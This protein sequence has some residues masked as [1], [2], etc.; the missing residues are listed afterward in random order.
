MTDVSV[1]VAV[2]VRSARRED[3]WRIQATI[4]QILSDHPRISASLDPWM[5]LLKI[6][7]T[8]LNIKYDGMPPPKVSLRTGIL[9]R[10]HLDQNSLEEILGS[11]ADNSKAAIDVAA[12]S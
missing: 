11:V 7:G 3:G 10:I 2:A 8:D 12:G 1:E 5:S 4:V 9:F 6:I